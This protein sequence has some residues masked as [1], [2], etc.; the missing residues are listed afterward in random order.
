MP[1]ALAQTSGSLDATLLLSAGADSYRSTLGKL[2]LP[3]SALSEPKAR[4]DASGV[5]AFNP[6]P[7]I[8]HTFRADEKEI[9]VI[10]AAL[11]AFA[12]LAPWMTL[13]A[14]V[15]PLPSLSLTSG[16]ERVAQPPGQEPAHDHVWLVRVPRRTGG[17]DPP[18]L[19]RAA[20]LPG[21]QD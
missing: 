20:S 3:A 6:Q 16:R 9:P 18:V 11:G 14:L 5:P 8:T 13:V 10:K 21:E 7:E 1:S 19:D 17:S 15:C 2:S 4:R 12:V